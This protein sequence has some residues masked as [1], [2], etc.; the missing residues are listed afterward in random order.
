MEGGGGQTGQGGDLTGQGGGQTGQG[1]DL[2]GAEGHV[3]RA[4]GITVVGDDD[5][6]IYSFRGAVPGIFSRFAE[7][8]GCVRTRVLRQNFRCSGHILAAASALI[9][10]NIAR[11]RKHV[12]TANPCGDPVEI[13]EC[14]TTRCE[15]DAVCARILKLRR[16]GVP[17]SHIAVLY[18]T[19][20]LGAE[21]RHE[22]RNRSLP[23]ERSATFKLLTRDDAAPFVSAVRLMCF[24]ADDEAFVAVARSHAQLAP[25]ARDALRALAHARGESQLATARAVHGALTPT[26][27]PTS[28]TGAEAAAAAAA[29]ALLASEP[30]HSALGAL[31]ATLD[32]LLIGARE[33]RS[34]LRQLIRQIIES[35]LL[36]KGFLQ[37]AQMKLPQGVQTLLEILDRQ[38][39]GAGGGLGDG[40]GGGLGDG[41]GGGL[42]DG[43]G[44]GDGDG[45]A[46]DA[47][48]GRGDAGGDGFG[49][50]HAFSEALA[51]AC[52][53]APDALGALRCLS[54]ELSLSELEECGEGGG[55]GHS[56][57]HPRCKGQRVAGGDRGAAQ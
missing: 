18:R 38:G 26:P 24:E 53:D 29:A 23:I 56:L 39:D 12:W 9:R 55:G 36:G 27:T 2:K 57:H 37:S 20:N 30:H 34:S 51:A 13:C 32:E 43:D 22:L 48:G 19:H 50:D 44:D 54:A 35:G 21:L 45:N 4:V 6:S 46:R 47:G 16:D 7:E 33:P 3:S 25:E 11:Q 41:N 31:L 52:A 14:R 8:I 1:G 28:P 40:N 10:E 42:G 49:V 15:L 17:F 5:Q